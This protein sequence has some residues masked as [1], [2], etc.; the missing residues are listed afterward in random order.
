LLP[1]LFFILFFQKFFQN[2]YL[3]FFQEKLESYK[4]KKII[5]PF[6]LFFCF[7]GFDGC[8]SDVITDDI[9][10]LTTEICYYAQELCGIFSPQNKVQK[11]DDEIKTDIYYAS[12]NLQALYKSLVA[13][14]K[15]Y[16][17]ETEQVYK[18]ELTKIRNKLRSLVQQHYEETD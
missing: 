7:C 8:G 3:K 17:P 6:L 2:F 11:N 16:S 15:T 10:Q 1:E 9:C 14:R 13:L 12:Q 4:M 18:E 5:F